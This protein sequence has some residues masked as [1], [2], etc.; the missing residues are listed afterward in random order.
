MQEVSNK[1]TP[2]NAALKLSDLSFAIIRHV[3]E[4]YQE[5]LGGAA[6]ERLNRINDP[7]TTVEAIQTTVESGRIA[8]FV[9]GSKWSSASKLIIRGQSAPNKPTI[10]K[11]GFELNDFAWDVPEALKDDVRIQDFSTQSLELQKKLLQYLQNSQILTA[12]SKR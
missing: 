3:F 6:L 10:I 4:L 9:I 5:Y 2:A 8:E 7:S 11:F 12:W 1:I